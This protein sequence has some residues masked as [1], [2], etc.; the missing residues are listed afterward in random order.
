VTLPLP[1]CA[2]CG[3][4]LR[5]QDY[6]GERVTVQYRAFPG[7][8]TVGWCESC[9]TDDA[10]VI[11]LALGRLRGTNVPALLREVEARGSGRVVSGPAWR[12]S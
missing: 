11:L 6:D 8:P 5:Q 7:S 2:G 10:L 3:R 1:L 9:G 12:R 4:S